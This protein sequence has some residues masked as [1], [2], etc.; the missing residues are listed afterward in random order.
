MVTIILGILAAVAIP[1]Y[2][3]TVEKAE[4]AAED[5]VISSIRAGLETHATEKL[6]THGR[7]EWPENPFTA[8]ETKP[9]GYAVANNGDP[10]NTA[11]AAAD[12]E[13]TYNIANVTVNSVAF[14]GTITHM[15]GDNTVK[16]WSY[17][18]GNHTSGSQVVGS[19]GARY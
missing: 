13:W 9:S 17:E 8:L 5:A 1:R 15:R 14:D 18:E 11:N 16:R 7:R 6:I 3:A 19:L 10:T 2:T 4:A 12:G